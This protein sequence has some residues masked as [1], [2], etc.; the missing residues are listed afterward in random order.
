[1][2][3]EWVEAALKIF[4]GERG[5]FPSLVEAHIQV[6]KYLEESR[7][8][9]CRASCSKVEVDYVQGASKLPSLN[10][11]TIK[12]RNFILTMYPR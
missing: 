9:L 10:V 3:E 5:V 4:G 6:L 1:M 7:D 11:D 2:W 8:N 12:F